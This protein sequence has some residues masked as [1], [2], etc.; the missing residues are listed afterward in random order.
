MDFAF[1]RFISTES[2]KTTS[3]SATLGIASH[4]FTK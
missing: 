4:L 2:M 3:W 1:G